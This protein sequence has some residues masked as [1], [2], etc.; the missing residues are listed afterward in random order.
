[1][2]GGDILPPEGKQGLDPTGSSPPL[3]LMH[4]CTHPPGQHRTLAL[5]SP[6]GLWG[7]GRPQASPLLP[8][9][10]MALGAGETGHCP[11]EP[12]PLS[13]PPGW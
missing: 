9:H 5:L 3:Q 6:W 4:P 10:Y 2:Q 13:L 8:G 12:E 7:A 1:M 11:P